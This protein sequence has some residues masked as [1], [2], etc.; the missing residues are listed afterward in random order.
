VLRGL[1]WEILRIW[2]TDW[3]VDPTGTLER[4]DLRLNELLIQDRERR[5]LQ[6]NV[7]SAAT[8]TTTMVEP[9]L[10]PPAMLGS[11]TVF[12]REAAI[13]E[14]SA[15]EAANEEAPSLLYARSVSFPDTRAQNPSG[16]ATCF[17][18]SQPE[19]AVPVGSISPGQFYEY[20]YDKVLQSMIEWVVLHEG[21]VLD[22]VLARR[23]ARA[24]GFQRTGNR[25]QERIEYIAKQRFT[26]TEEAAGCFYWPDGTTP[27]IAVAFRWPA[28]EDSVRSVE[29]I[30]EQE[31]LSLARKIINSGRSGEDALVSMAREIG[32]GRLRAASRERLGRALALIGN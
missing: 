25:I 13:S 2:S 4:V 28:D 7:R 20:V 30:C 12:A 24:H 18:A 31:L 10:S 16:T 23:I 21:P 27:D 15:Q 11:A 29:E 19:E 14:I 5:L 32:L 22:A 1:G 6:A 3:W 26:C 9:E 17:R 8:E